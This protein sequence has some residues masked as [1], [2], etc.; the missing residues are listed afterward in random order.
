M[1]SISRARS[2]ARSSLS[3]S[4]CR[5]REASPDS[6]VSTLISWFRADRTSG[7]GKSLKGRDID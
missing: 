6:G 3:N 1:S 2:A 4:D 7:D 5:F